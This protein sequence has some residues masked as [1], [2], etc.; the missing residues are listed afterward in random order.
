[1]PSYQEISS[2]DLSITVP[3]QT[4]LIRFTVRPRRNLTQLTVLHLRF[5]ILFVSLSSPVFSLS[6]S[7]QLLDWWTLWRRKEGRKESARERECNLSKLI[8]IIPG[9]PQYPHTTLYCTWYL[10]NPWN[11]SLQNEENLIGIVSTIRF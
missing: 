3:T 1:M 2:M 7:L 9:F 5:R 8:K 4:C 11:L 10:S 6:L